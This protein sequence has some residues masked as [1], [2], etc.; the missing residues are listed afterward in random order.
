MMGDL[1]FPAKDLQWQR[2]DD[3]LI[4]IVHTHRDVASED[5]Q[6]VRLQ[7]QKL[8]DLMLQ[9]HLAQYVDL[10][11]HE[12]EILDLFYCSDPQLVTHVDTEYFPRFTDHKI[13]TISVNYLLGK[14]PIKEEMSLLDSGKRLKQ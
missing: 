7:A 11:T 14:A 6:Q 1:N 3:C 9:H 2:V 8:C 5:G 13:L 12:K 4:P 10:I